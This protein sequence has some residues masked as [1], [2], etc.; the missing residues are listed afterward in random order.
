[1]LL[2]QLAIAT[3]ALENYYGLWFLTPVYCVIGDFAK[4]D[5]FYI[6][7]PYCVLLLA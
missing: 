7:N 4:F 2:S 6:Y 3:L 5:K 1:M